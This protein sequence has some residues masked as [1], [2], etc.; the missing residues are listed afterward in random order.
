MGFILLG[1]GL[2]LFI[3]AI[4]SVVSNIIASFTYVKKIG[5]VV[6]F[7][8]VKPGTYK[9]VLRFLGLNGQEYYLEDGLASS[10]PEYAQGEFIRI[11]LSK[12]NEKIGR[13]D[14]LASIKSCIWYL[15]CS[16]LFFALVH[17]FYE[18]KMTHL[19]TLVAA[20]L[21]L[22]EAA[23]FYSGI[24]FFRFDVELPLAK[25]IN[26]ENSRL[27]SWSD[28]YSG[29]IVFESSFL[30]IKDYFLKFE[31]LTYIVIAI[32]ALCGSFY[33][34]KSITDH[35]SNSYQIQA[36]YDR[37][38]PHQWTEKIKTKIPMVRYYAKNKNIVTALDKQNPFYFDLTPGSQVTLI[39][40][41]SHPEIIR[42]DR[43]IINYWKSFLLLT[44]SLLFLKLNRF[45]ESRNKSQNKNNP[46]IRV[47]KAG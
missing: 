41:K 46:V 35:I 11:L 31:R 15:V 2:F 45:A 14:H 29:H 19:A 20:Y 5:Q 42:I 26:V 38:I 16:I 9:V 47:R 22:S 44:F 3:K 21:A 37:P 23:K 8:E 4:Y 33:S 40:S 18:V 1:C 17:F 32:T 28:K 30:F 36:T 6:G 27:I 25:I 34:L 13:L 39:I 24:R 10:A 7:S 12:T 43:G